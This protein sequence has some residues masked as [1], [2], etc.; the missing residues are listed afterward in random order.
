MG[1][2]QFTT[3]NYEET[4]WK[5][6]ADIHVFNE[7]TGRV[8][9]YYLQEQ[10][11]YNGELFLDEEKTMID[12]LA[13]EIGIFMERRQVEREL[14]QHRNNLEKL[15]DQRTVE[16]KEKTDKLEASQQT[17]RMLLKDVNATRDDLITANEQLKVANKE[18]ESFS[19]SISHDLRA[20]LRAILGFSNKLGALYSEQLDAEGKRIISVIGEN[21]KKMGQLIDDLLAFSRMGRLRVNKSNTDMKSLVDEICAELKTTTADRDVK[22]KIKKL[23]NAEVDRNMMRQALYNLIANAVKFTRN[24]KQAIIE[25]GCQEKKNEYIYYVK[26]NGVGFDLKYAEKLFNVFQRLHS[27]NEFEGTGVGLAIVQRI[28]YRHGGSVWVE[29]ELNKG[30]TFYY[31]LP[32]KGVELPDRYDRPVIDLRRKT[33]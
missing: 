9:V 22:Y 26:D 13:K 6:A 4:I 10:E 32:K 2:K 31:T 7:K 23:K 1:N 20:P 24:E 8:E 16:L 17:M 18:L 3:K 29:A 30:A 28:I 5:L 27:E 11:S 33:D 19:Y 21:T 12:T 25:I 14:D 15:V